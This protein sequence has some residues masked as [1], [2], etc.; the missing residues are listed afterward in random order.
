MDGPLAPGQDNDSPLDYTRTIECVVLMK[1]L[2]QPHLDCLQQT[3]AMHVLT[4][5][6]FIAPHSL[7]KPWKIPLD[8]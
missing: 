4:M 8:E 2:L 1:P 5:P 3:M 6:L 7:V